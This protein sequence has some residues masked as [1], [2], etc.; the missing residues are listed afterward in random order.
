MASAMSPQRPRDRPPGP[1]SWAEAVGGYVKEK[2]SPGPV[3]EPFHR[4][5]RH[6]GGL[7]KGKQRSFHPVLQKPIDSE[8]AD[9]M[10]GSERERLIRRVNR[11]MERA[12][13]SQ[14]YIGY[15][16]VSHLP[17]YGIEGADKMG[18]MQTAKGKL[19]VQPPVRT[20][21]PKEKKPRPA[22][23][24]RR[25]Y[26]IVKHRYESNH[27]ERIQARD[28][29]ILNHSG[30]MLARGRDPILGVVNDVVEEQY[31]RETQAARDQRKRDE[32]HATTIHTPAVLRRSEGHNYDILCGSVHDMDGTDRLDRKTKRGLPMRERLQQTLHAGVSEREA[33]A[34]RADALSFNRKKHPHR[35]RDWCR[36]GYD[37]LTGRPAPLPPI[38]P[39]D[40]PV[41]DLLSRTA[42]SRAVL[43]GLA[44]RPTPLRLSALSREQ[45]PAEA[46]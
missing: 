22:R 8:A 37:I 21:Q 43:D 45:T 1:S 13:T 4:F 7:V 31:L 32:L 17:K 35:A 18:G 46:S 12:L 10:S 27:E 41:C 38:P 11:G 24:G 34:A 40:I 5:T 28:D 3:A 6:A 30:A 36:S 15:D 42:P 14:S 26:D 2:C 44:S 19:C 25:Q 20:E 9:K 39:E 29:G 16:P 23:V 33:R